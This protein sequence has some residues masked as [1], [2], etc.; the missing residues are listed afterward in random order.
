MYLKNHYGDGY[1]VELVSENSK[2]L[3]EFLEKEIK[4]LK[5]VDIAGG[6]LYRSWPFFFEKIPNNQLL[7]LYN[8]INEL[9]IGHPYYILK[10]IR[11]S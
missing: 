8:K 5:L 1:K 9:S 6:S 11:L 3:W 2:R 10:A 7:P 4:S